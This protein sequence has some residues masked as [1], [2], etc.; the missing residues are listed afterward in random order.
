MEKGGERSAKRDKTAQRE[1]ITSNGRNYERFEKL[2][3]KQ[4]ERAFRSLHAPRPITISPRQFA[5]VGHHH[6]PGTCRF[7][8][9][10][11]RSCKFVN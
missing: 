1:A 3:Y 2:V 10:R 7:T 6:R 8:H 9:R 11:S 4:A 5:T